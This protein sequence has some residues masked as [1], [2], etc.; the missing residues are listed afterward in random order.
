[1]KIV[2]TRGQQCPAPIIATKKALRESKRGETFQVLTDNQTSLNNLTRF[3]KDTR[4]SFSV[5][6][7]KGVWTLTVTK[8]TAEDSQHKTEDYCNSD[9][10]HFSQ[11]EFII[12]FTSDKMGT[13][14]DELGSLLMANFIKAVKDLD[15]LPAKMVF[16]NRG[17]MLGKDDSDAIEYLREI[18]K[19]GVRL[20][21]CATCVSYYS[22]SEKIHI[23][24]FSNMYEIAQAMASASNVVKP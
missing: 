2:D 20:L 18:E 4:T 7:S 10:P 8:T 24:S 22:L 3:L 13:G 16:Y 19:M 14:D 6:E 21:L 9:I 11:G 5:S 17:V 23:G 15:H 1:M 12:A